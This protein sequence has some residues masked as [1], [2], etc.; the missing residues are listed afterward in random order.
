M[1]SSETFGFRG[2][3]MEQGVMKKNEQSKAWH[4]VTRLRWSAGACF[5]FAAVLIMAPR[6]T[7]AM[8][9]GYDGTVDKDAVTLNMSVGETQTVVL[10]Y[11]NTG[12]KTWVGGSGYEKVNLFLADL[13]TSPLQDASWIDRETPGG[14]KDARVAPG[15]ST[16]VSF[17]VHASRPGTFTEIVRLA[18]DDVAWMRSAETKLT[19]IVSEAQADPAPVP[20]PS[21]SQTYSGLLL[22]RS[23]RGLSLRGGDTAVVTYGFKNTGNVVWS[24]RSLVLSTVKSATVSTS[25]SWVY[26]ETWETATK[27]IKEENPTKPG[28]IG[29]LTFELKAP[30]K[31]GTYTVRFAL[32]ADDKQVEGAYVD[33]PVTVTSDGSYQV[34]PPITPPSSASIVSS[35]GNIPNAPDFTGSEPIVRVGLFR[36]TD[37][38]MKV[39]GYTGPFRVFQGTKTICSF[40][41]DQEATIKFDRTNLVYKLTGPGC[42]S[43]SSEPYKVERTSGE[44][45]PLEMSDFHRPVSWYPG[46]D[47]NKFRGILELRYAADDPDHDVWTI[48]ELPMELYLR[49]IAETS[50][51]SPLEYQKALLIAA[52]TYGYYHWTRGTK[53]ETRGFQ[54]D[55]KYDQVYRGYGAEARSPKIVQAVTE[56]RGQ[57]VT[58]QGKLAITPYFSRSDGRTRSWG[59]VWYGGSNYPWL[60]T[61]PV[62]QDAGRTLWGHGVGMSASGALGMANEGDDYIKILKH[63]YTGVEIMKYF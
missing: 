63:F 43:Q 41:K 27:A 26:H 17:K 11:K 56:T 30:P 54:I 46:A 4:K 45:D 59:E 38:Q 21:E 5:L 22:L 18:A 19:V 62:P 60:V 42:T 55:G 52:R 13:H 3:K 8:W 9:R 2:C 48:N 51:V 16:T 47:D 10:T 32:F 29:F 23:T 25:D 20:A 1:F 33:I 44:W 37:D 36:T 28:E 39:K 12:E 6:T 14:I 34:N 49:G 50:D 40:E 24:T 15:G 57:I 35:P 61:V 53:H 31:R 58:Y 7:H